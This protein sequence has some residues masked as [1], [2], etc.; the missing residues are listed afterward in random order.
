MFLVYYLLKHYTDISNLINRFLD[1]A[2]LFNLVY[3]D[4]VKVIS[5]GILLVK[6]LSL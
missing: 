2:I 5:Y 3:Y 6:T 1:I 4:K